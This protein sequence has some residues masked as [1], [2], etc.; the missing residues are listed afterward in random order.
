[1][2]KS[3]RSNL[4]PFQNREIRQS[5]H[6][7][8]EEATI[9]CSTCLCGHLLFATGRITD[10]GSTGVLHQQKTGEI[11]KDVAA[12]ETNVVLSVVFLFSIVIV[13]PVGRAGGYLSPPRR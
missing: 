8:R 7:R 11:T 3:H 10:P 5:C 9:S 4:C 2:T 12:P 6:N 13:E 1:M